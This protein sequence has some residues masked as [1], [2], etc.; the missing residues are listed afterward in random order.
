MY[1]Q[2]YVCDLFCV[3]IDVTP[4]I[5]Y[6]HTHILIVTSSTVLGLKWKQW[7]IAS[8]EQYMG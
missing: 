1:V 3:L 8:I 2:T 6:T 4:F 5:F 7:K